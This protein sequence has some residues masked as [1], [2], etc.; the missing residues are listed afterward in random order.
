VQRRRV[1]DG[2]QML[3]HEDTSKFWAS[4]RAGTAIQAPII[5]TNDVF[6]LRFPFVGYTCVWWDEAMHTAGVCEGIVKQFLLQSCLHPSTTHY[7]FFSHLL[8]PYLNSRG[9]RTQVYGG[10][11]RS[12]THALY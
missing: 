6:K 9:L 3:E 12:E 4:V 8:Q 7:D 5:N 11:N 10:P 2:V 1:T